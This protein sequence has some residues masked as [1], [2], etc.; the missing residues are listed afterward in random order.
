MSIN[1]PQI[2]GFINGTT[3]GD[4]ASQFNKDPFLLPKVIFEN[5]FDYYEKNEDQLH[6]AGYD[7]YL[8][9]L[10]F[11]KMGGNQSESPLN[12][13]SDFFKKIVNKM[14]LMRSDMPCLDLAG[15]EGKFIEIISRIL[16]IIEMP[17][18]R[19]VFKLSNIPEDWDTIR[20]QDTFKTVC[21]VNVKWIDKTN[22][23]IT[24]RDL[25]KIAVINEWCGAKKKKNRPFDVSTYASLTCIDSGGSHQSQSDQTVESHSLTTSFAEQSGTVI[26]KQDEEIIVI[27]KKRSSFEEIEDVKTKKAKLGENSPYCSVS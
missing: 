12:L 18:R 15:T 1:I 19:H 11:I 23:F 13:E 5:G 10:V 26:E 2:Q 21:Q 4:L 6:E 16:N 8:T 14:Y 7:A 24:L 25:N 27:K 9:G 3:L 22:A 17:T 20:L